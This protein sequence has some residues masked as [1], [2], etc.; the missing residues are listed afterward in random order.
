MR[1]KISYLIKFLII[2]PL[3]LAQNTDRQIWSS[4]EFNFK[5]INNTE[6][7]YNQSLRFT[8]DYTLLSHFFSNLQVSKKHNKWLSHSVGYRYKT[9]R[10]F[11]DQDYN[12]YHRLYVDVLLK[13][14][15]S[16]KFRSSYRSR[17]QTQKGVNYKKNKV[18]QKIKLMYDVKKIDLTLYTSFEGFYVL[19]SFYE[20]TRFQ[21]GFS[22]KIHSKMNVNIDY[23]IQKEYNKKNPDLFYILRTKVTYNI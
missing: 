2:S 19:N 16:K 4:L 6:I 17:L 10:D 8:E 5:S 9:Q 14:K 12:N 18:R 20:R 13:E 1:K 23:M 11:G 15:F 3:L 7:S 21:F 22:K